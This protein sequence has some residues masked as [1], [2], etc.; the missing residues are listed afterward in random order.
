M[1]KR[2]WS[3]SYSQEEEKS[4]PFLSYS[5]LGSIKCPRSN[6]PR[7]RQEPDWVQCYFLLLCCFNVPLSFDVCLIFAT[8]ALIFSDQWVSCLYSILSPQ[9]VLLKA[10]VTAS[11]IHWMAACYTCYTLN[12][13]NVNS[14]SLHLLWTFRFISVCNILNI[15]NMIHN[16]FLN[17]A[18]F[19]FF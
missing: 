8:I 13:Y 9:T 11:L 15:I 7:V 1:E 18:L 12:I 19:F 2:I 3:R 17:T 6:V 10:W 5:K 16:G 4:F 14:Y